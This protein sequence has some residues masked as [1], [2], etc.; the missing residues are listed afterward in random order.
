MDDDA[1]LASLAAAL[2]QKDRIDDV[3]SISESDGLDREGV[4][5]SHEL[6]RKSDSSSQ[7]PLAKSPQASRPL[8]L[9]AVELEDHPRFKNINLVG[10]GGMGVV[11][12]AIDSD[13]QEK[14]SLKS[15]ADNSLSTEVLK[16]EFR[17]LSNLRHPNLVAFKELHVHKGRPFFTMEYVDGDSFDTY[18]TEVRTRSCGNWTT[19]SIRDVCE[20]FSQLAA[21][22]IFLHESNFVHRDV[23]PSNVLVTPSGR[24]VLLDFGLAGFFH[25]R[26]ALTVGG[27][28]SYM[29]PEQASGNHIRPVSDWFS[30]GVMLFEVLFG[31]RPFDGN[32]CEVLIAKLFKDI[33]IPND[34]RQGIPQNLLDLVVSLLSI[35]PE[36]RPQS[37]VTLGVLRECAGGSKQRSSQKDDRKMPFLGRQESLE[38]L[39]NS[40]AMLQ[41]KPETYVC[42]VEGE[43]GVGKTRLISE[44]TELCQADDQILILKGQ[45]YEQERIPYKA[46]DILMSKLATEC[47]KEKL[48]ENSGNADIDLGPLKKVFPCFQKVPSVTN[49]DL[50]SDDDRSAAITELRNILSILSH[51]RQLVLF[52]DDVQWADPDSG[53]LLSEVIAGIPILLICAHRC[54]Q[55]ANSFVSQ[56]MNACQAP[57]QKVFVRPLENLH[58][59]QLLQQMF[60]RIDQQSLESTLKAAK[61]IPLMLS[62]IGRRA[63]FTDGRLAEVS[64]QDN[65][66]TGSSIINWENDLEPDARRLLQ[67]ICTASDPMQQGVAMKVWGERQHFDEILSTLFYK[68]YIRLVSLGSGVALA[69]FHDIVRQGVSHR[70]KLSDRRFLHNSIAET[71]ESHGGV[72]PGKLAY[73]FQEAGVTEKSSH[74]YDL[75]GDL[76]SQSLA[77]GEAVSAYSN[78]LE[79]CSGSDSHKLR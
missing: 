1:F 65:K 52:I 71:L 44:F 59:E 8:E 57:V 6:N 31:R 18:F 27:T 50:N 76:A 9:I 20:K 75:A 78:A 39:K 60:P 62:A 35:S 66:P 43:S 74:Y 72:L 22:L 53:A 19:E 28:L 16:S 40:L 47:K 38:S 14:V 32:N 4:V 3:D 77:F 45:C 5:D 17:V 41:S 2:Q 34:L 68:Q 64:A 7:S 46:I 54:M 58:A 49:A 10:Y 67:I 33:E 13:T 55:N 29:P 48:F 51:R 30:F 25:T 79:N 63:A 56:I 70:M 36:Q 15:L 24:V 26:K 23:K 12:S 37:I 69:P 61:G 73:H 21:G 42:L 11:Y